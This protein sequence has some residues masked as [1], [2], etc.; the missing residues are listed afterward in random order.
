MP[1]L[2]LTQLNRFTQE[3][4]QSLCQITL[5]EDLHLL[6]TQ[7]AESLNNLGITVHRLQLPLNYFFGLRHPFY[8][9]IILTWTAEAGVDIVLRDREKVSLSQAVSVW[10]KSPYASLLFEDLNHLRIRPSPDH[11][12][13]IIGD[14]ARQGYQDYFVFALSL[15]G[16]GKAMVSLSTHTLGGFGEHLEST[17]EALK[18][19]MVMYLYAA[20]KSTASR[21]IA[22]TYLGKRTGTRVINGLFYRGDAIGI[23]ALILFADLRNF[24]SLSERLGAQCV[25]EYIN[26]VFD[27]LNDQLRPLGGEILKFIGDAALIIFPEHELPRPISSEQFFKQLRSLGP[28]ITQLSLTHYSNSQQSIEVNVPVILEQLTTVIDQVRDI[29][30]E[31]GSHLD[32][33]V[34]LHFGE[35][36]YGNMGARDRLDFTVM[37]PAVNLTSRL[38]TLSK[39]LNASI[40][41][42]EEVYQRIPKSFLSATELSTHPPQTVKGVSDPVKVW[43]MKPS[44]GP[45]G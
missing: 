25:T 15:P 40:I 19:A 17:I 10:Q 43:S 44:L 22:T 33:G 14:L 27:L 37:G 8:S 1:S 20:L 39:Q 34:G 13:E 24:T 36:I 6:A 5:T 42:S 2:S 38:E 3:L 30:L 9:G 16:E 26:S 29:T 41:L 23:N 32:L 35:V 31:D 11:Q 7:L 18:P 4:S 45:G 12:Y 21:Q 28:D